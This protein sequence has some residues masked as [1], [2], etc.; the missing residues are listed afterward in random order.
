MIFFTLIHKQKYSDK[1]KY[2]KQYKMN[3]MKYLIRNHI[4]SKENYHLLQNNLTYPLQ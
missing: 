3:N 1:K 2:T 4:F